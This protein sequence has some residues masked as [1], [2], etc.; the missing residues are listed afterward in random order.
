VSHSVGGSKGR[1]G[2]GFLAVYW[3]VVASAVPLYALYCIF[4]NLAA[5]SPP[6]PHPLTQAEQFRDQ[7]CSAAADEEKLQE[8]WAL[9][10]VECVSRSPADYNASL[11]AFMR[12]L[13]PEEQQQ[14]AG[15]SLMLPV[16]ASHEAEA[17][18]GQQR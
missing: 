6:P 3:I 9:R 12:T 7:A 2:P 11:R 8:G 5:P 18:V 14:L 15:L 16:P 1:I 13:T 10:F 4:A 17:A